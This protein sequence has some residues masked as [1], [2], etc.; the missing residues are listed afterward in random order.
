MRIAVII[1][2]GAGLALSG[3]SKQAQSGSNASMGT[4]G[5]QAN[6]GGTSMPAND[7]GSRPHNAANTASRVSQ[8]DQDFMKTAAQGGMAEVELGKLAQSNA[9][10]DAVKKFGERMV[11]DHGQANAKLNTIAAQKQVNLPDSPNDEQKA[12]KQKLEG[13]KGADFD[14]EY[15]NAMVKDH[16]E[17][18]A[19]FHKEAEDAGD[20]DLKQFAGNSATV[21]DQHLKLAKQIDAKVK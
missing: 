4:Q 8:A 6:G 12:E 2:I 18:S 15:M 11:S 1:F 10:S 9:Q 7:E 20:P 5:V 19:E 14:R 13:L 3:C 21:I 16:T 17:D